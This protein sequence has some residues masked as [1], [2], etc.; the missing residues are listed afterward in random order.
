MARHRDDKTLAQQLVALARLPV[1]TSVTIKRSRLTWTGELQPTPLSLTYTVRLGYAVGQRRPSVTV[2][3][4]ELRA[5]DFRRLPHVFP[6]DHLCLCY[7][8]QWTPGTMIAQTIVP[9][10]AEWLLHFEVWKVTNTWHG[11]GHEPI[12]IAEQ[13]QFA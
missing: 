7:P 11:G 5:D 8:W 6:Q 1:T 12:E 2:L 9:W 4:P 13:Q 3:R 10:T